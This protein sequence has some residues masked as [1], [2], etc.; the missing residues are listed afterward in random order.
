MVS[1]VAVGPSAVWLVCGAQALGMLVASL[2]FLVSVIIFVELIK[3]K[4][5]TCVLRQDRRKFVH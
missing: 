2:R 4:Q 3:N 1:E 5:T